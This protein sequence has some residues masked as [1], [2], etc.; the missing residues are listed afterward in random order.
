MGWL[1]WLLVPGAAALAIWYFLSLQNATPA[2]GYPP[3]VP[4]TACGGEIT[5]GQVVYGEIP[6][7]EN[8]DYLFAG[9]AGDTVDIRMVRQ[10]DGF[11]PFVQLL[12]ENGSALASDDDTAGNLNSQIAAYAL[13]A[14]G[15]YIISVQD[16]SATAGG[17]FE[18]SLKG[19]T[20]DVAMMEIDGVPFVYVPAGEFVM[21]SPEGVGGDDEHPL[22]TVYLDAFWIMQTEVTNAQ[23]AQCIA[24][25]A[26]STPANDRWRDAAYGDHPVTGVDW[27][28]A[29]TYAQWVGGRLPTEAEWEK[30]ARGVDDRTYP[31]GETPPAADLVN[32]C[33]FF[34]DT[35]PVGSYPAGA[36][37][38]GV[39]DM[40]GNVWEWT[41]DWYASDYYNWSP[42]QNPAGPA[43]GDARVQR[44]G[45]AWNDANIVRVANRGWNHPAVQP[46]NLGFRVASSSP[47]S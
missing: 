18:L 27:N 30:A 46:W 38:Y 39:L 3:A 17:P 40:A 2:P 4:V 15:V 36:S 22:H 11:D 43:S 24:A 5:Y 16:L 6:T 37:D 41:A 31:W 10:S 1:G 32:C 34:D 8:C 25:G 35:M 20:A 9:Q 26:C 14:N 29:D 45:S 42:A 47:G 12:D 19:Q 44:G 33:G 13:P 23:Y 28:Q 21:G 7:G